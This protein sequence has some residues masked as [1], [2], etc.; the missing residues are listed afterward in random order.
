[1]IKLKHNYLLLANP[2]L[3]ILS[4]VKYNFQSNVNQSKYENYSLSTIANSIVYCLIR[5]L[6]KTLSIYSLMQNGNRL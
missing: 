1:M 3:D 5:A 4:S 6:I 2:N